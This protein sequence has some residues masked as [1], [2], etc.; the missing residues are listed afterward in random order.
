MKRL[1][2]QSNNSV[3]L[4]IQIL[5]IAVLVILYLLV[6]MFSLSAQTP[7]KDSGA[8]GALKIDPVF[9]GQKVPEDFWSKKHLFYSNGDTI[10][11]SFDHYKGKMLVLDFWF[12]GCTKCLLHQKEINYFK[13]KYA[14]NLVVIMVNSKNT[15]DNLEKIT[16]MTKADWFK[17]L[18]INNF[19][20]IIEDEYLSKML[21]SNGYPTYFWINTYGILQLI[22]FRNLLDRN[23][24]APF[25]DQKR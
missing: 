7:R 18:G 25:I 10:R 5:K 3:L 15:R 11:R 17:Q 1:K 2:L 24:Q 22:T 14:D 4:H 8:D 6:S 12:T 21:P 9:L 20:S 13:E 19:T 23:Y 16:H